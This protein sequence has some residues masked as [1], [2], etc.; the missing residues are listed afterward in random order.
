MPLKS[1]NTN[2]R[3]QRVK[4]K[5]NILILATLVVFGS[6]AVTE[7]SLVARHRNEC[8]VLE[9]KIAR[10]ESEA[11][12][13]AARRDEELSNLASAERDLNL[14][15]DEIA[16]S[17][18]SRDPRREAEVE[19]W[20]RCMKKLKGLFDQRPG[21]RIPEMQLLKQ[22]DWIRLAKSVELETDAQVRWSL[23]EVRSAAKGEFIKLLSTALEKFKAVTQTKFPS[24]V[25]E[26]G[27][28]FE[29][30][31]D[32]AIL[33]RYKVAQ[34]GDVNLNQPV[35]RFIT[36]KIPID[37]EYDKRYSVGE[38]R[39]YGSS[40]GGSAWIDNFF[41]KLQTAA[42]EYARNHDGRVPLPLGLVGPY[43]NPPLSPEKLNKLLNTEKPAMRPGQAGSPGETLLPHPL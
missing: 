20:L 25:L 13:L 19:T 15:N 41:E 16:M 36:E 26:L 2:L 17:E 30:P 29:K 32:P 18:A 8:R 24:S 11:R 1:I 28:Y 43:M 35:N 4:F 42:R 34:R 21:Q 33:E 38:N 7:A 12:D 10:L 9:S 27:P 5:N 3:F 39:G 6:G 40:G 31:I 37:D 23:A 14:L 22:G